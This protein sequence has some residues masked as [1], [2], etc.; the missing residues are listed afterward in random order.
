M[1]AAIF[2]TAKSARSGLI[3][4]RTG[5]DRMTASVVVRGA[6]GK[7]ETLVFRYRRKRG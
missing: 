1:L 7:E 2:L 6:G 5:R 4:Q 3:Y